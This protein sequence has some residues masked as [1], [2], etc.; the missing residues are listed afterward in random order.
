MDK[1][2]M[3]NNSLK[4]LFR[5]RF[6]PMLIAWISVG[7]VYG[8]T[9]FI[10]GEKWVIPELWLDQQIPFSTKAVWLYLSFFLVVPFAFWKAELQRVKPMMLAI[11]ISALVSGIFFIFFPT[12]LDYPQVSGNGISDKVFYLLLW[13][14]TAQNCFPS[15][16]AS[17]TIICL[18]GLWQKHQ[19]L[20]NTIYL[21][22][23]LAI[24]Y[25]IIQLRRHLTLDVTAGI[26]VGALA[27]A[28]PLI[29]QHTRLQKVANE[30]QVK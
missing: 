21:A 17:I 11:I 22:A 23:T 9:R 14:D 7:L 10:G 2:A 26:L 13:I 5:Q 25:A 30:G 18:L 6:Y 27:Y 29:W 12:T 15:L 16:H 24:A 20:K 3:T 28:V 4:T 1:D 19:P 8:S